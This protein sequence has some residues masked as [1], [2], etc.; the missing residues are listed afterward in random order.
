MFRFRSFVF[1]TTHLSLLELVLSL[2]AYSQQDTLWY[3]HIAFGEGRYDEAIIA[4]QAAINQG[5][6][7]DW[8]PELIQTVM[9]RRDL[10]NIMPADTHK[11]GM[12]FVT[13]LNEVTGTGTVSASDV[14]PAQKEKWRVYFGVFQKTLESF[15]NG[16]WTARID[17]V[18]ATATYATGA[19]RPKDDPDHLNLEE[20]F[21]LRMPE[22]DSFISLSNTR[23][24]AFGLARRYP[25]VRGVL[26]GPHR[27]M[28]QINAGTHGYGVLL[29][30]FFHIVEWA[31]NAISPAHGYL[32]ENRNN[33]PGWTDTTEFSY[34]RWHFAETLPGV[35]WRQLNHRTRWIPFE[36]KRSLFDSLQGL[37]SGI[38]L[39]NRQEADSLVKDGNTFLGSDSSAAATKWEEAIALSPYQEEGLYRL[40]EYYEFTAK[41][42]SKTRGVYDQLKVIRS[43]NDFSTIDTVNKNFGPI[44]GRWHREDIGRNSQFIVTWRF[45]AWDISKYLSE[46]GNYLATFYYTHG[47]TQLEMD[48]VSIFK[49]GIQVSLDAHQG[50]TGN[51]V[52]TNNSYA[53]SVPDF[54]PLSLYELK[55]K[56]KGG[57]GIDS[58]G[59]IHLRRTG[60][61]TSA[62]VFGHS[63]ITYELSQN[64]PNPFNSLTRIRFNVPATEFVSLAVYNILGQAVAVLKNEVTPPGSFVT[65]FDA[66]A[67]PSGVYFSR[68]KAGNFV[69]TK[70]LILVR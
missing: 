29:H 27:G 24:P 57:G 55:A 45:A 50:V 20:F 16:Q 48:S 11:I 36:N 21:F 34:Y 26:Y 59:Q 47:F 37:Y 46:S 19:S 67:L 10:G 28:A 35:R 33:F 66:H 5:E 17:T 49:D 1:H 63:P 12:I 43:V 15:S 32:P 7:W 62:E 9:V 56:I 23:S 70:K 39:E 69:D 6:T 18:D 22:F 14:T 60:P 2:T 25:Y 41:D 8:L 54:N 68:M 65:S 4:Y 30:E 13:Q 52:M 58:Y 38:T 61:A 42:T 44:V 40:R 53:L 51:V 3:G 31:S 64:F